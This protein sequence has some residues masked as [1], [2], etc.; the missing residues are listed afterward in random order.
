MWPQTFAVDLVRR[1]MREIFPA[2]MYR[3]DGKLMS[4]KLHKPSLDANSLQIVILNVI[5]KQIKNKDHRK[6]EIFVKH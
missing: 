1:I 4:Y 2:S 5:K 3:K 6:F